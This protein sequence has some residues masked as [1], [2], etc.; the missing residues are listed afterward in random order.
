EGQRRRQAR[1][2]R[3]ED[4]GD[5]EVGADRERLLESQEREEM[6]FLLALLLL[7]PVAPAQ[8]KPPRPNFVIMMCD[9]QRW[10]AMSIAGNTI[11]KTPHLDRIRRERHVF[12][13]AFV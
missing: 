12:R 1:R 9:D 6:R 3:R 13:N 10:D 7:A 8:D 4:R 2:R 11:L 5:P